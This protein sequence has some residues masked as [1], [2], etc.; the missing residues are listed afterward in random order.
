[1]AIDKV[2]L[3][4]LVC[5]Q[6]RKPLVLVEG[7]RA[8]YCEESGLKYPVRDD[9]P[10]MLLEEAIDMQGSSQPSQ[11]QGSNVG[12]VGTFATPS[13]QLYSDKPPVRFKVT[14]GPKKGIEVQLECG[15]C[16]AIGRAVSDPLRTSS[17]NVDVTLSLDD[18]TRRLIQQYVTKQFQ[19]KE[20]GPGSEFG[21][22]RTG[23]I[24]LED[25]SV[26]RLHAMIF[27][28][29]VGVGVL[30]LVSKNGTYVNGDEVESRLLRKGD[31]I[32][33]GESKLVFEG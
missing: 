24:V 6:S 19:R 1:M 20:S 25:I 15:T 28:D 13:Q 29:E 21:F 14:A 22:R 30:D 32:E 33:V 3:D 11:Q 8:L 7:G 10:I 17:F 26:S 27:Y 12:D 18:N 2:L 4:I 5:I 9:V 16:K 31:A 23:D